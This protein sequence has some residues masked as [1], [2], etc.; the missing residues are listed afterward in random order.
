MADIG[1]MGF[2]AIV[3]LIS[4]LALAG[5][6]MWRIYG[7]KDDPQNEGYVINA[8]SPYC[9]GYGILLE[10][11]RESNKNL[12]HIKGSPRDINYIKLKDKEFEV[13]E[14]DIYVK[15]NLLIPFGISAHRKV[16]L[17]L[18]DKPEHLPQELKDHPFGKY[19]MA[20]IANQNGEEDTEILRNMRIDNLLAL[21]KK[22]GGL[23]IVE[24]II[25]MHKEAVLDS[26]KQTP[27][28]EPKKKS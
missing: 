19:V 17:V 12:V 5:Y 20:F 21:A 7:D 1:F 2:I 18:P 10:K 6:W 16:E 11:S 9:K 24:D 23:E 26:G 3:L 15:K 4:V 25:A 8:L 14:Q 13:R 28:E 22:T 27:T